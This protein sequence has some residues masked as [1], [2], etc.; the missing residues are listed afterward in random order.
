[1]IV[2]VHSHTC[3]EVNLLRKEQ[4]GQRSRDS[5]TIPN[6]FASEMFRHLWDWSVIIRIA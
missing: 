2:H 6:K 1:M 3:D 4:F 5:T